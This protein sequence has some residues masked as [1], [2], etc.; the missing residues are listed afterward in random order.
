M[1]LTKVQT[2][3]ALKRGSSESK[4][5]LELAK[6][7]SAVH[8]LDLGFVITQKSQRCHYLPKHLILLCKR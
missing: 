6:N 7:H 5:S 8:D 2:M 3:S 1:Q 4:L